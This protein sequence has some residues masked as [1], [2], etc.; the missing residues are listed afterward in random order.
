MISFCW[1][2]ML[3]RLWGLDHFKWRLNSLWLFFSGF[4]AA[5][6]PRPLLHYSLCWYLQWWGP[7]ESSNNTHLLLKQ[8][9]LMVNDILQCFSLYG[10]NA[11]VGLLAWKHPHPFFH[12]PR[13]K[14]WIKYEC[15]S[16][17][18]RSSFQTFLKAL[19]NYPLCVIKKCCPPKYNV[20][21][22]YF[23]QKI[24]DQEMHC[25]LDTV[26]ATGKR[27]NYELSLVS[28]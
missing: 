17:E 5:R 27:M 10:S 21:M 19:L 14:D 23:F 7:K 1:L 13:G 26:Y 2:A 22:Y 16:D 11:V 28:L 8:G 12:W 20:L 24:W 15:F 4:F 18:P 3:S 25:N 9:F 6:I